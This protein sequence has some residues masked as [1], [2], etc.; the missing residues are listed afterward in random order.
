MPRAVICIARPLRHSIPPGKDIDREKENR[1]PQQPARLPHRTDIGFQQSP[2]AA[3][4]RDQEML[5]RPKVPYRPCGAAGRVQLKLE[6]ERKRKEHRGNNSLPRPCP[7]LTV[8]Q[9]MAVARV[10][11]VSL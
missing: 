1:E 6:V 3:A 11:V 2:T 8:R 5:D 10:L 7:D 9:D 4:P